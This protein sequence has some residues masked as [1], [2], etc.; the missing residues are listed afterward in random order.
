MRPGGLALSSPVPPT[1]P[2]RPA[3]REIGRAAPDD[4]LWVTW[5]ALVG[6]G[7][8]LY[9]WLHV[10]DDAIAVAVEL[11]PRHGAGGSA[12]S[13]HRGRCDLPPGGAGGFDERVNALLAAADDAVRRAAFR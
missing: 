13:L 7:G 4:A 12:R 2:P 1:P 8:A 3:W 11:Q 9:R 5:V 10:G 6:D